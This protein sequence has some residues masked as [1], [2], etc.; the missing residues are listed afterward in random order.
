MP[1]QRPWDA[2]HATVG[3][4]RFKR[5]ATEGWLSYSGL[6]GALSEE[7]ARAR[8]GPSRYTRSRGAPGLRAKMPSHFGR[9]ELSACQ[10]FMHTEWDCLVIPLTKYEIPRFGCA[11][12][13][14]R[15]GSE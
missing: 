14:V 6:G 15:A 7:D 3:V 9:R 11:L 1:M 8:S 5:R 13:S 4:G 12:A 10:E 2:I